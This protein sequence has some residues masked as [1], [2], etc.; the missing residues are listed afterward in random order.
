M[1][2]E[3]AVK[4][5]EMQEK[6]KDASQEIEGYSG[7]IHIGVIPSIYFHG[8]NKFAMNMHEKNPRLN[9]FLHEEKTHKI[10]KKL[11]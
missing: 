2:Y 6:W 5:L 9:I 11:Y 10:L 3:D 8:L 1:F 7:N 4:I